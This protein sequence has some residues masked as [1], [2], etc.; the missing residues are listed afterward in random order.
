VWLTG[1]GGRPTGLARLFAREELAL[2][3]A[4]DGVDS[5]VAL[6]LVERPAARSTLSLWDGDY[7]LVPTAPIGRSGGEV[8]RAF[9]ELADDWTSHDLVI[10]GDHEP[11]LERLAREL[12]VGMRVHFV[13]AA[14]RQAEWAWWTHAA[15]AVLTSAAPISGGLILRALACGCP[16][17]VA[18]ERGAGGPAAEWLARQHCVPDRTA[19]ESLAGTIERLL[20]RGSEV[21]RAVERG[22]AVAAVHDFRTLVAHLRAAVPGL[23]KPSAKDSI[24][25]AA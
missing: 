8:L 9:A 16:L 10:L 20:E 25:H 11:E 6:G 21:E 13:G 3:A 15:A 4:G 22:R 1:A 2:E 17:H 7:V 24:P 5:W 14:E 19:G 12:D 23:A 18:G